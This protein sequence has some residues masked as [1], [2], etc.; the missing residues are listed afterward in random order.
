MLGHAA[1]TTLAMFT[2]DRPPNH[3]LHAEVLF[4]VLPRL[5]QL[6]DDSF[7]LVSAPGLGHVARVLDHRVPEAVRT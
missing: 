1:S 7:L 5:E 2:A 4:V 3:A 6:L